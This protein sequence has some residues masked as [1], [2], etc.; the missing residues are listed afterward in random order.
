MGFTNVTDGIT[1]LTEEGSEAVARR[2]NDCLYQ[3]ISQ[4][5]IAIED[6]AELIR[7]VETM[8]SREGLLT[9][10][11][12]IFDV[13]WTIFSQINFR[14]QCSRTLRKSQRLMGGGGY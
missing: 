11:N 9:Y 7:S 5:I 2:D 4:N 6:I 1:S 8:V 3:V 14:T 12:D 10:V 13:S